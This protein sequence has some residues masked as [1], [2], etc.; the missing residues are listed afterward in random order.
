MVRPVEAR[1]LMPYRIWLRYQD[2]TE[3]EVDL[4]HLAGKGGL[5]GVGSGRGVRAGSTRQPRPGRVARRSR[6]LPRRALPETYRET[7]GGRI[8]RTGPDE[9][10][11]LKSAGSTGSS[12]ASST[13]ITI[14]RTFTPSRSSTKFSSTST[15]WQSSAGAA[16]VIPDESPRPTGQD[17]ETARS[18]VIDRFAPSENR[19]NGPGTGCKYGRGERI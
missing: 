19:P 4:S 16:V 3:G 15:R 13:P 2:G 17:P 11:C 10:G 8:H 1:P 18:P 14:H 12:F 6:P 7:A 5:F 9:F